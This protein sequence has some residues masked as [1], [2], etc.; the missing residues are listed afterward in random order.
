MAAKIR[1]KRIGR[2]GIPFYRLV[3]ADGRSSRDSKT[4]EVLGV[5]DPVQEPVKFDYQKERVEYWLSVG[6][7]PTEP[8]NRLLGEEGFVPKVKKVPVNPGVSKKEKK[9][10][11]S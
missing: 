11:Q 5:Y 9:A 4:L 6:A 7:V 8:V 10:Q 3:V 1:L 2:K